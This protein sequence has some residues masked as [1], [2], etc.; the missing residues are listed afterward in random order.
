MN[1]FKYRIY[2]TAVGLY[3]VEGG[4]SCCEN[5]NRPLRSKW[6]GCAL[7]LAMGIFSLVSHAD[8]LHNY[9]YHYIALSEALLPEGFI[10][11]QAG[12]IDNKRQ[13]YGNVW[14]SSDVAHVAIYRD[15]TLS[16]L[17]P[18]YVSTANSLGTIGG[19]VVIDPLEYVFQ[20]ALFR[21]NQ[22]ELI[23]FQPG[24][25]TA[26]VVS[27]NDSDIVIVRSEQV[28]PYGT[29]LTYRLIKDGEIFFS[30]QLPTDFDC[31]GCWKI[32]NQGV[33]SGQ[34]FD[35]DLAAFR[36]IRFKPPY[37][38][39]ELLDPL[40]EDTDSEAFSVNDSG[41][42]LGMSSADFENFVKFHYGVWDDEGG[43]TPYFDFISYFGSEDFLY[44]AVFNDDNLLVLSIYLDKVHYS[45]LM[46]EP[47]KILNIEDLVVN[48]ADLDVTL[49]A[50]TDINNHGDII[51]YGCNAEISYCR[52]FLL[53]NLSK[54][55]VMAPRPAIQANGRSEFLNLSK[56]DVLTLTVALDPGDYDGKAS[57][58]W[59]LAVNNSDTFWFTLDHG[60]IPSGLDQ[61]IPV[62]NGGLM[63]ISSYQIFDGLQLP[64]GTHHFYFGVDTIMNGVIDYDDL[65]YG[66]V[67]VEIGD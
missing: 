45:Y 19:A 15:G 62:Y 17:Q 47:S 35:P 4:F 8:R 67:I 16:V 10:Q 13:V 42:I 12:T 55:N 37:G 52:N 27:I 6:L 66:K 36:A 57:D 39:P 30:Y 44:S 49:A 53:I 26:R 43:F 22:V 24:D 38:E 41:F 23:P 32:N 28:M 50:I 33:V 48:K 1:K 25:T 63:P 31:A 2:T 61:P 11:F 40:P 9:Q 5:F 54:A 64:A 60:W 18:G 3:S 65:S 58:W 59:I 7:A 14:D 21:G 29:T 46:P 51:G 34:I 20:A 56:N